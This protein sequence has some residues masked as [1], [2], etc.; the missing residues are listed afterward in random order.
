MEAEKR[1]KPAEIRLSL[2]DPWSRQMFAAL[3][4]RYGPRPYRHPRMRR[5]SVIVRAPETF[6]NTVL[7][8][9]FEE[10]NAAPSEH[11]AQVI[12]K[13]TRE[14]VYRDTEDADELPEPAKIGR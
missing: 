8:P 1:E 9:E 2:P 3:C 12:N 11:L 7:W 10:I 6:L 5:Q 14:A 4:R 13:V